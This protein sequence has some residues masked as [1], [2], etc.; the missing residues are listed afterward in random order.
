[1][2]IIPFKTKESNKVLYAVTGAEDPRE[3]VQ[4]VIRYKKES[5]KN[6]DK[7]DWDFAKIR[8]TKKTIELYTDLSVKGHPVIL[9]W[10]K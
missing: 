7:F 9:V 2:T 4:T 6:Y 3:A 1:M 5:L 8:R 10:K